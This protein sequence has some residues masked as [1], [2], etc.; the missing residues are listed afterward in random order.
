MARGRCPFFG[1]QRV[2]YAVGVPPDVSSYYGASLLP[3]FCNSH[4]R[5][6]PFVLDAAESEL[7]MSE[8]KTV[9]KRG[10]TTAAGLSE[11]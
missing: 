2:A 5:L 9:L 11:R 6:D 3:G 10:R 7:L 1:P 4:S 8:R